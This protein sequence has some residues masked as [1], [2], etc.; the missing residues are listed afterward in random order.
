MKGVRTKNRACA[1]AS[2]SLL[3]CQSAMM[4]GMKSSTPWWRTALRRTSVARAAVPAAP[5]Q[6]DDGFG[7][8]GDFSTAGGDADNGDDDAFGDFK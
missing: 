6:A 2:F 7:D 1:A 3:P 8:F 4:H 5:E